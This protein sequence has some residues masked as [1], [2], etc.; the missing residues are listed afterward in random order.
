[1]SVRFGERVD[2]RIGRAPGRERVD[3]ESTPAHFPDDCC[4]D[5]YS[6]LLDGAA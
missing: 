3:R 4:R 1:M 6:Y 5:V 2:V